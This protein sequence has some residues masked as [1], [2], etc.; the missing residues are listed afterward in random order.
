MKPLSGPSEAHRAVNGTFKQT[1]RPIVVT[2]WSGAADPRF[3][4]P[5]PPHIDTELDVRK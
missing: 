3:I 5:D 2:G 4:P 1:C